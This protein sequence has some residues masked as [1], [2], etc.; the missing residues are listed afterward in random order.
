MCTLI[1]IHIYIYILLSI[2]RIK[3][4]TDIR[5]TFNVLRKEDLANLQF[6]I[7]INKFLIIFHTYYRLASQ[8]KILNDSLQ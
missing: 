7:E 6:L 4:R 3:S 8:Y 5:L 1:Y 2:L